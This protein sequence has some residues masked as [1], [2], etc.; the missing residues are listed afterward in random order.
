MAKGS[1]SLGHEFE[2]VDEATE[3]VALAGYAASQ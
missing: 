1:R 3:V 2:K